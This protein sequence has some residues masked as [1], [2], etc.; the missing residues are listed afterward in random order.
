MRSWRTFCHFTDFHKLSIVPAEQKGSN[1]RDENY[2]P[3]LICIFNGNW[4]SKNLMILINFG[5]S[6]CTTIIQQTFSFS[7]NKRNEYFYNR[8]H[9]NLVIYPLRMVLSKLLE[10]A[11]QSLPNMEYPLELFQNLF[12][13]RLFLGAVLQILGQHTPIPM[14]CVHCYRLDHI[15]RH[16]V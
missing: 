9:L 4:L 13:L 8:I 14:R 12:P 6:K 11:H 15:Q 10:S 3:S 7:N 16:R 5:D 2:A 1:K